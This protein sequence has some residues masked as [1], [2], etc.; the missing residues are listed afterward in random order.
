MRVFW[1]KSY[2]GATMADLT[3]AIG[4]NR[5]SIY[6][7]FGDKESLFHRVMGR[8]REGRMSSTRQALAQPSLRKVLV[9]CF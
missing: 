8:Y 3:E 4:I 9:C 2:E 5:S 1:E 7:A 6:A